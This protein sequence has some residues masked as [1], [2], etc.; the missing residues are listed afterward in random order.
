MSVNLILW[1]K[2][3]YLKIG[4]RERWVLGETFRSNNFDSVALG[5]VQKIHGWLWKKINCLSFSLEN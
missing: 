1:K 5:L 3:L 4:D 2:V